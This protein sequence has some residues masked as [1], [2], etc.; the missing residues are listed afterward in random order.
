[1][2]GGY[3][4]Y[5]AGGTV[6]G[7]TV[8]NFINGWGG[9]FIFP[10]TNR[11]AIVADFGSAS[12]STA[13]A[14]SVAA[15]PQF[16]FHLGPVTPFIEGMLGVQDFSPKQ[17]PS[18]KTATYVLGAGVDLKL[19][20]RISLR[21]I[22]F[23]YINT[24]YSAL[25]KLGSTNPF[26]GYR[27]QSGVIFNFGLPT[28]EGEVSAACVA[29]PAT[30]DVGSPVRI[31][32]APK[33]FVPGRTLR[34]GYASTGGKVAASKESASVDTSGVEPGNYTVTATVGDNAKKKHHQVVSCLATFTVKAVAPSANIVAANT[35]TEKTTEAS[36]NSASTGVGHNNSGDSSN[37]SAVNTS[38]GNSG[39]GTIVGEQHPPT[40]SNSPAT[41]SV[42][43][44]SAAEVTKFGSIEFEHDKTRPTRVDNVAKGELDR[45]ADALAAAPYARG[46]VVGSATPWEDNLR[47][48][49]GATPDFAARRAV[50]TKDY[51]SRDKGIDP[52]RIE[53]RAGRGK[54]T[55]ELWIVSSGA[56]FPKAETKAVDESKVKA[57]PRVTRKKRR[58]K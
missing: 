3:S 36:N 50:N 39:E 57:V 41:E 58:K 52:S 38:A 21:P 11:S 54:Q 31:G 47:K 27:L 45:Y 12:N 13:S 35:A 23:D 53:P 9:Q 7:V 16:R 55:V 6:N 25:S 14:R 43:T 19:T 1:L 28:Q 20:R 17:Y 24:Y 49:H 40:P 37:T 8:P 33:G 2:F 26:N 48:S 18:Q 46:V 15:G 29:D 5:D 34:Y 4:R 56:A 42:K 22:H 10:T 30:V 32:V 51:L 44:A